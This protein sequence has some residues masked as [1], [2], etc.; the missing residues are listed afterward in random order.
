VRTVLV[1]ALVAWLG[2]CAPAVPSGRSVSV[3]APSR[4]FIRA[5]VSLPSQGPGYRFVR[6][7]AASFGTARMVA[8]LQRVAK[9]VKDR[10]GPGPNVRVGDIS[11]EGGGR[12][13]GHGSH[14]AGRDADLLYFARGAAGPLA[15][16][17]AM[18][19]DRFGRGQLEGAQYHFDTAR[20][21][22]LVR[23]MLTDPEVEVQWIFCSHGL[24]V[25]LLEEALA[26]GEDLEL[27]RRA[28]WILHRP[29]NARPHDDHLHVR[30]F[31]T[32]VERALGCVD[33][34]PDWD[35]REREDAPPAAPPSDAEILAAMAQDPEVT[36]TVTAGR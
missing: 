35:W 2:A 30:I 20:N 15:D 36:A 10:S 33:G 27:V 28:A 12:I 13:D 24:K 31:C 7:P 18:R 1:A 29:G 8:F 19:F 21:W 17:G 32:V 23:A 9:T 34:A 3:G 14:R 11:L 6:D 25:L 26:Q 22:A 5:A 16:V 4:G